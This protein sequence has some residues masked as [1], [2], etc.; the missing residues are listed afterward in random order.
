MKS[1][2]SPLKIWSSSFLGRLGVS[3]DAET[4]V[5]AD[6]ACWVD[7]RAA[8]WDGLP[9]SKDCVGA[10]CAGK[11]AAGG[12]EFDG[13]CDYIFSRARTSRSNDARSDASERR[14]SAENSEVGVVL[15]GVASEGAG[16]AEF[17]ALS[18]SIRRRKRVSR[19]PERDSF[20]CANRRCK[21]SVDKSA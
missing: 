8:T 17:S 18:W 1:T 7:I 15:V 2:N 11:S 9:R 14:D 5:A 16:A 20:R 12:G 3:S 13:V 21:T 10:V 4:F 6:G 19:D